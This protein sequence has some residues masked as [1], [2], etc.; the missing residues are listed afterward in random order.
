[1]KG[2]EKISSYAGAPLQVKGEVIGFLDLTSLTPNFYNQN[3]CR[4]IKGIC[5]PGGDRGGECTSIGR[6]PAACRRIVSLAGYW[7]GS[8]LRAGDGYTPQE[9]CWRNVKRVLPIEAFYI[10]TYDNETE[11]DRFSTLL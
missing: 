5:R 9:R 8:H 6:S 1:M 3:P 7:S 10:A 4:P 2:L 11:N